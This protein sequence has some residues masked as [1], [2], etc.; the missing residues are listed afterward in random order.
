MGARPCI[1]MYRAGQAAAR[2]GRGRT[3]YIR[4]GCG[5]AHRF[6]SH[7][8]RDH[9]CIQYLGLRLRLSPNRAAAIAVLANIAT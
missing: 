2:P 3:D 9:G 6:R 7:L 1:L 8:Q 4:G 5:H